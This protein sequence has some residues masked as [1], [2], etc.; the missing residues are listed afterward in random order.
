MAWGQLCHTRMNGSFDSPHRGGAV[1][2]FMFLLLIVVFCSFAPV[3][4]ANNHVVTAQSATEITLEEAEIL[5]Y[6]L[7]AAQTT[8]SQGMDI[9]WELQT[10]SKLDQND[11]YVFWVVNNK[12]QN[13]HGSNT[14]G[15]YGVNKHTADIWSMDQGEFV[16][17]TEL[18][19]VQALV[20][21]A[22]SITE[23]VIQKYRH[24]RP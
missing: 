6:L 2:R 5:I 17:A 8:R 11:F 20:R 14:I 24:L 9:G 16:S 21:R 3:L 13:V 4:D 1:R 19:G 23:T 22:H 15:Y 10:S 18:D 7:P 12:R